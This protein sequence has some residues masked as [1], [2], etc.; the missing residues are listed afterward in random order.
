[1]VHDQHIGTVHIVAGAMKRA[2]LMMAQRLVAGVAIGS[3]AIP[4]EVGDRLRPVVPIPVPLAIGIGLPQR[5]VTILVAL[6][7]FVFAEGTRIL[8]KKVELE[9]GHL[10]TTGS[11]LQQMLAAVALAS[12]DQHK[13]KRQL[14]VAVVKRQIFMNELLL[15]GHGGSGDHQLFLV[16]SGHRDGALSIGERFADTGTRF[17]NQDPALLV[18]LPGQGFGDLGHQKVLLFTRHKTGQSIRNLAIGL[19]NGSFEASGEHKDKA[20]LGVN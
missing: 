20:S 6:R 18:V 16:Q 1:M 15:Q 8:Q 5:L 2:V 17:G 13:A 11:L 9:V 19:T 4:T 14:A 7:W 10:G 3:D 12:L